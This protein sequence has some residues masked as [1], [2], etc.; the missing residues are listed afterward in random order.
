M[1][2]F[3]QPLNQNPNISGSRLSMAANRISEL[4]DRVRLS[5]LEGNIIEKQ[6]EIQ[7]LNK[8]ID[9]RSKIAEASGE[10]NKSANQDL[11]DNLS[12]LTKSQL[13]FR[14][15]METNFRHRHE[16]GDLIAQITDTYYG[17][18][19]KYSGNSGYIIPEIDAEKAALMAKA[20]IVSRNALIN[21]DPS[22]E[23]R[24]N[25]VN[26]NSSPNTNLVR[27]NIRAS[28]ENPLIAGKVGLKPHQRNEKFLDHAEHTADKKYKYVR[29]YKN[30]LGRKQISSKRKIAKRDMNIKRL[31]HKAIAIRARR[32]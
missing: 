7:N 24:L 2:N 14:R 12:P 17:L 9:V 31:E 13:K 25:S 5:R 28:M 27:D 16:E 22:L 8:D 32:P 21:G 3:N 6:D 1:T 15:K 18:A 20:K 29:D 4:F 30:G 26:R 19:D 11:M 23:N 10:D